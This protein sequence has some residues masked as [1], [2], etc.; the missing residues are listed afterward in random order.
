MRYD[1][2]LSRLTHLSLLELLVVKDAKLIVVCAAVVLGE[3]LGPVLAGDSQTVGDD[4]A[5]PFKHG[6]RHDVLVLGGVA[7]ACA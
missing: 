7:V 5:Q 1:S 6:R 2:A 4:I 3:D